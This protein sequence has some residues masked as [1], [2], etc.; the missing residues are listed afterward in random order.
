MI[1]AIGNRAVIADHDKFRAHPSGSKLPVSGNLLYQI[2]RKAALFIS[3]AFLFAACDDVQVHIECPSPDNQYVAAYY[4]VSGG[5]AAGYVYT[6]INIKKVKGILNLWFP[7]TTLEGFEGADWIWF[8]WKSNR[9]L[10]VD[11]PLDLYPDLRKSGPI[12]VGRET[13]QV[14]YRR[15]QPLPGQLPKN[16]CKSGTAN[17]E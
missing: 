16:E 13:I 2:I 4:S 8:T 1:L 9:H 7:S 15:Q 10:V 5:G 11:Y 3:L 17:G 6:K 14:E 12:S